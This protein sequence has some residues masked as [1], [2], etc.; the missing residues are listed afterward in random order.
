MFGG[1]LSSHT[2]EECLVPEIVVLC[3][4]EVEK[5]GIHQILHGV[6]C[7]LTDKYRAHCEWDI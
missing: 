3:V 2:T 7:I 6:A 4:G 5:K 1:T